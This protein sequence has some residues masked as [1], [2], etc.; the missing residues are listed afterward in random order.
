MQVASSVNLIIDVGDNTAYLD[1]T[2]SAIDSTSGSIEV[3]FTVIQ[4]KITFSIKWIY[5][6]NACSIIFT[7]I[8]HL[9]F[10]AYEGLILSEYVNILDDIENYI[11]DLLRDRGYLVSHTYLHL[12]EI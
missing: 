10:F 3:N 5:E 9:F 6:N 11:L 4:T 1:V 7:V 2:Y 8:F 12:D